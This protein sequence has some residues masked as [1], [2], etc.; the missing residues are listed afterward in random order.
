[1]YEEGKGALV[2]CFDDDDVV[3]TVTMVMMM[4]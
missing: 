4:T 2:L 1:M 3:M